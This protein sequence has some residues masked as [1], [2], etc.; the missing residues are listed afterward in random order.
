VQI[1]PGIFELFEVVLPHEP[2]KL[3]DLLDFGAVN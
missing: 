3:L 2:E 1:S